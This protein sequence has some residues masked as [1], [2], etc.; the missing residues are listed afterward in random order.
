MGLDSPGLYRGFV[1]V[2]GGF[3]S[4]SFVR[5]FCLEGFVRSSSVVI[6]LLQ[7]KAKHHFKFYVSYA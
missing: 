5:G 3:C 6:H 7:Q 4:R 2:R 1:L